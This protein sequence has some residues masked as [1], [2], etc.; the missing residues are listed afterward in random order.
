MDVA[1][2]HQR[3][4]TDA[5]EVERRPFRCSAR[6]VFRALALLLGLLSTLLFT[7]GA[8]GASSSTGAPLA[9]GSAPGVST[10]AGAVQRPVVRE[11]NVPSTTRTGRPPR[12]SLR[13]DEAGVRTVSLKV[14]ITDAS[15]SRPVIGARMGWVPT[16]RVLTVRW[17]TRVTLTPG[18]YALRLSARA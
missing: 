1:Q 8:A 9:G 14:T 3:L 11:L 16:G 13:I 15:T 5:L 18:S 10:G 17:P 7:S 2:T 12:V 6:N 4:F